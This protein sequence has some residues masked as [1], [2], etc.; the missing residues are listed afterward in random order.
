LTRDNKYGLPHLALSEN[1]QEF[2]LPVSANLPTNYIDAYAILGKEGSTNYS[3]PEIKL[4]EGGKHLFRVRL[5]LISSL[6][7]TE[8]RIQN[9]FQLCQFAYHSVKK[10]SSLNDTRSVDSSAITKS[11]KTIYHNENA[12]SAS[13]LQEDLSPTHE[14][15]LN[16][17]QE[18]INIVEV[19]F[20]YFDI[21]VL[22]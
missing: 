17:E 19:I 20:I 14:Q 10:S 3:N 13:D 18:L 8:E 12:C 15:S 1:V 22:V 2:D 9:F 7:T 4:V 11:G 16:F 6:F 5:R 21:I